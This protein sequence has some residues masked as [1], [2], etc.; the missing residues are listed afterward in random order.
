[1]TQPMVSR[2]RTRE[3]DAA[4]LEV[5]E[6][7]APVRVRPGMYIGS[8]DEAGLR[9]LVFEVVGNSLDEHL[10]GFARHLEVDISEGWVSIS[11]DG[12]GI[13]VAPQGSPGIPLVELVMTRLGATSEVRAPRVD[14]L[15]GIGLPVVNALSERLEVE[16]RHDG[17]TWTMAFSR[18]KVVDPLTRVRDTTAH[19]TTVRFRPDP[20]IFGSATLDL[21]A[22]R[23][24]LDELA[25]LTS[26][27]RWRF[28]G[29]D[30]SHA[31]GL[32][33]LIVAQAPTPL[34]PGTLFTIEGE[35]A[36]V[37]VHATIG[38][39]SGRRGKRVGFVNFA[40]SGLGS[41]LRG[42]ARGVRRA[43]P[44]APPSLERRLVAAVHVGVPVPHFTGAVR[45]ALQDDAVE[46]AVMKAT[47]RALRDQGDLRIS[48]LQAAS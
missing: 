14:R 3:H 45:R 11:D 19:G 27:L 30:C 17:G 43:F 35:F 15:H 42:V 33:G 47:E 7:L 6:G 4:D 2:R 23:A 12:R 39:A 46:Q 22:V 34:L 24:R 21:G 8:T 16:T 13:S 41:H 26:R 25:W 44:G 48:W 18:G 10:A 1:M 20:Q 5:L 37:Q 9:H 29:R 32:E 40:P 36:G 28:E 38:L 31:D